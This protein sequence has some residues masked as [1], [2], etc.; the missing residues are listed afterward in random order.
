MTTLRC[1]L[2]GLG[3]LPTDP[4]W[5]SAAERDTAH[6]LKVEKRRTDWLLGRYAAKC[7]LAASTGEHSGELAR[8]EIRADRDGA[9]HAWL[10]GQPA[11]TAISLSHS[12]GQALCVVGPADIAPG[13]DLERIETRDP[14]FAETFFTAAEAALV[15]GAPEEQRPLL[16]TLIWSAKESALKVLRHGLRKDTRSVEVTAQLE[17]SS[18]TW[19]PLL[20][21]MTDSDQRLHGWWQTAAGF[22]LTV[23]ADR[24]TH[25][26]QWLGDGPERSGR[27]CD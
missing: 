23:A 11:P 15:T 10:D 12:G 9:P 16:G 5:L 25:A 24:R 8:W 13:C 3:D 26:P 7:A 2:T 21:H 20:L 14:S 4:A 17:E 1:L 27:V 18:A 19:Q 22:V 6:A